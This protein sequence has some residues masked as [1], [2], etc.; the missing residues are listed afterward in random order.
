MILIPECGETRGG[1][2]FPEAYCA[3]SRCCC[4]FGDKIQWQSCNYLYIYF[5]TLAAVISGSAVIAIIGT[6]LACFFNKYQAPVLG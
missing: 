4:A 5:V 2:A 1:I 6:I 3:D